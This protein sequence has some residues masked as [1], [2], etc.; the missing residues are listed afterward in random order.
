MKNDNLILT[1]GT[2]QDG[3]F[4]H[5]GCNGNCCKQAQENPAL[6]RSIASISIVDRLKSKAWI[7]DVTPDISKQI[8]ILMEYIPDLEYPSL[9]GIFLTH[10]HIG[11]YIGLLYFGL[12]ALNLKNIP[13]Y[14]LPG[15]KKFL[16]KNSMFYQMIENNNI[17]IKDLNHDSK[18]QLSED[19]EIKAF[20]VPHRNELS[21]TVGYSMQ[22]KSKSLIYIP[23]ID[24]WGDW[25]INLTDIIKNNDIAIIDGT[26]FS[27]DEIKNRD[28]KKIPHPSIIESMNLMKAMP[29]K[30]KNKVFFTHLNHTNRI[31]N[32]KSQEYNDVIASG[33]N[34][35]EDKQIFKL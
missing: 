12:E 15:M 10:A 31:L 19:L 17:I 8:R 13:V 27:K 33:Y 22:G 35:L 18:I 30:E 3:G 5:I 16:Y 6:G 7:I 23:D 11:H 25:D 34:I 20:F 14:V 29:L 1:L 4:P 28:I 32:Y 21:E 26:F 24:S 9:S 2:A